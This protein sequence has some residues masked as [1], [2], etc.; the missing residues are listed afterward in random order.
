MRDERL[1]LHFDELELRQLVPDDA[2]YFFRLL[3]RNRKFLSRYEEGLGDEY[4]TEHELRMSLFDPPKPHK[5]R[6]GIWDRFTFIG[7][8][9]LARDEENC[10]IAKID[11]W[12]GQQFSERGYI[13][14]SSK[15]LL[16]YAF[17]ELGYSLVYAFVGESNTKAMQVLLRC[18]MRQDPRRDKDGRYYYFLSQAR[19]EETQEEEAKKND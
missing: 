13:T 12:R 4:Q 10:A 5:L 7:N 19:W 1:I 9:N 18:G 11:F 3:D 16:D 2:L 17:N 8:V 14:R 6:F 15:R